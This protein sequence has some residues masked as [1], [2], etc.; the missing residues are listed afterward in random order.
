M[1]PG[2]AVAVSADV[3]VCG[4]VATV[5][6]AGPTCPLQSRLNTLIATSWSGGSGPR[7]RL[8]VSSR[9]PSRPSVTVAGGVLPSAYR[10]STPAKSSVLAGEA[11]DTCT[12]LG[13]T[14]AAES[15]TA[16]G[17]PFTSSTVSPP[18]DGDSAL[19]TSTHVITSYRARHIMALGLTQVLEA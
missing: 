13:E 5:V 2:E 9:P 12:K 14:L 1:S 3:L 11:Q 7:S 6:A 4:V 8:V 15:V 19:S 10:T 18:I 16:G 17:A